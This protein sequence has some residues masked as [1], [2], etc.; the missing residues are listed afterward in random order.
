MD[1]APNPALVGPA[2]NL[3]P[4]VYAVSATIL[5][6]LPWRLYDSGDPAW[7]W[8]GPSWSAGKGRNGQILPSVAYFADLTPVA[9]VGHSIFVYDVTEEDCARIN[10]RFGA[11]V[12][13]PR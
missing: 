5:R 8:R 2:P 6:G 13:P 12:D 3:R 1:N 10:P 11:G 4:G 7:T 9:K